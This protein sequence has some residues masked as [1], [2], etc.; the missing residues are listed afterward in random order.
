VTTSPPVT[1]SQILSRFSENGMR[2]ERLSLQ[3]GVSILISQR[4]GR[5]F[6]PFLPNRD[7]NPGL[8][9]TNPVFADPKAFAEFLRANEWNLGGERIWIAPEVQYSVRDRNN[10][11]DSIFWPAAVDPGNYE[12]DE[13]S[14][15]HWR[16]SQ[17]MTLEAFNLAWGTKQLRLE[18]IITRAEDPLRS[19]ND[20]P[21]L[22]EGVIFAGY[23]HAITLSEGSRDDIMSESWN[24]IQLPPGGKIFIP[25]SP[26]VEPVD[27]LSPVGDLQSIQRGHVCLEITGRDQYKVG[28]KAAH[29]FGRAGYLGRLE[30]GQAYA[31]IRNYPNHPSCPYSK[32]RRCSRANADARCTCTTTVERSE[33]SAS[34]NATA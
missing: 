11:W 6:G 26:A 10:F 15:G 3:N 30:H 21:D 33:A 1:A 8:F 9:W 19:L 12:L 17:D 16:L 5:I 22:T 20:W 27:Y 14:P 24:L 18:R 31:I 13:V 32:S 25:A 7:E 29:V 4:G 28:F 23:E 2:C 34:W